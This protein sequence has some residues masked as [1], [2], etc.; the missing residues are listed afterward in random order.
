MVAAMVDDECGAA[1]KDDGDSSEAKAVKRAWKIAKWTELD[2]AE[3]GVQLRDIVKGCP[4]VLGGK[5]NSLR[6]DEV[7]LGKGVS[8]DL[9][10]LSLQVISEEE[11]AEVAVTEA[12]AEVA[13][14][15]AGGGDVSGRGGDGA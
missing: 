7:V 2:L 4:G 14:T 15:A 13:A 3:V 6:S 10:P 8:E 9:L 12:T 11:S 5:M 1:T